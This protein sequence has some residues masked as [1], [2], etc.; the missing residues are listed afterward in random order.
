MIETIQS[1]WRNLSWCIG[2]I[3]NACIHMWNVLSQALYRK[4]FSHKNATRKI[5]QA[6]KLTLNRVTCLLEFSVNPPT[7]LHAWFA[8]GWKKSNKFRDSRRE[9]YRFLFDQEGW[10]IPAK[11]VCTSR[12]FNK[13][14]IANYKGK[15]WSFRVYALCECGTLGFFDFRW[16]YNET[17][18]Q[19]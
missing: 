16:F 15:D 5:A 11:A 12:R 14:Q 13:R 1:R 9:Y 8:S 6:G 2:T 3:T 7:Q 18:S 4:N 19:C 10:W 17:R